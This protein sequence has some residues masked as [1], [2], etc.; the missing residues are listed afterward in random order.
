MNEVVSENPIAIGA[1]V[2]VEGTQFTILRYIDL[3]SV[4]ALNAGTGERVRLSIAAILE[5][6][7][8]AAVGGEVQESSQFETLSPEDWGLA[9]TRA[10]L[11]A[12]LLAD[13]PA[14]RAQAERIAKELD[15][16]VAT[17]YRWVK[18]LKGSG[19]IADL[20]PQKPDGGRGKGRIDP[21]ADAIIN[22][23]IEEKYLHS[24]RPSIARLMRDIQIHCRRASITPPH[25]NTVRRRV[26][27]LSERVITERRLGRKAA[28]DKFA[29]RPG[30][31]PGADYPGAVWQIDH[32]PLDLVV[33]DDVHRRHIGRPWLTLAIDVYS[34]CVAG[35]YLSLDPPSEVSV[36]MCLVHAMLPKEGWLAALDVQARWPLYGRPNTVHADNGKEFRGVMI[37]R[38]AEQH[39]FRM[40]WRKV[41]T[42]N[43]GGHI[44]RLMGTFNQEVHALPGTT[45]SSIAERGTYAPHKEAALTFGELEIYLT[46]YICGVY[47]QTVHS[48]VGRAPIRR[49]EVG[50]LGDGSL[51]GRGLP[52]PPSDPRRL[53]LDFM[54]LLERSIQQY[55]IRIDGLTY[56]D[57]VL[58]PW[59]R[60]VDAQ[61]RRPRRFM[62]RRDPRDI[63][64]VY[65]LDPD[66]HQYYPI[67]FRNLEHPS[68]TLWELREVRNQLKKEGKS[69]VDEELVFDTYER[70]NKLVEQAQR[71]KVT[72]RKAAQKKRLRGTVKAAE[73]AQ[74]G[75]KELA[76]PQ[77]LRD[78]VLS[79]AWDQDSDVTPFAVIKVK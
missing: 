65:F 30:I 12:P 54:P 31:F 55:G 2:K 77:A 18:R 39:R 52:P 14:S 69:E 29:S 34:R 15:V 68:L 67:P 59:I 22:S 63:S 28:D 24:Q 76:S 3:Y 26:K 56:Y 21:V 57:P 16:H 78:K 38:A 1:D 27:R 47:H 43:W 25:A 36:G 44:E 64:V 41:K 46:D 70:L 45:F 71:H 66:T 4:L 49:Y 8:A 62:I 23:A 6:L 79:D 32:T 61:T 11:L 5:A 37:T 17:V 35:F 20:A 13:P 19:K 40:E 58:D 53:R 33:V 73:S 10:S 60:S 72:A 75:M 48:G 74:E 7:D 50:L 51:P 9:Q 42:P